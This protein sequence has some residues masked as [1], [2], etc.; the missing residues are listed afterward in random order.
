M[1]PS[2]NVSDCDAGIL[3]PSTT[4]SAGYR[5]LFRRPQTKRSLL[6]RACELIRVMLRP[7][8]PVLAVTTSVEKV[9]AIVSTLALWGWNVRHVSSCRE[10]IAYLDEYPTELV[11]CDGRLSDGTWITILEAIQKMEDAPL[12]VASSNCAD[13]AQW[14]ALYQLGGYEV[15][16]KRF[17]SR[18]M[19]CT[20][21]AALRLAHVTR[22]ERV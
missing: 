5:F 11:L 18:E 4:M 16:L 9:D 7:Q 6:R 13:P 8:F 2:Q 10:A 21:A 15:V 12:L 22:A 14:R 19:R 3:T 17:D 1:I 20:V